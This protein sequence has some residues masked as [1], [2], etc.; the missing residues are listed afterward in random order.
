MSSQ[1]LLTVRDVSLMLG[2][3]EREVMDLAESGKLPAYK[4]G[5][6]YL[7]FKLEQVEEFKKSEM[8]FL[9]KAG[10]SPQDSFRDKFSDFIYFYD[11]YIL[12]SIVIFLILFVIF[13]GY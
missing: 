9:S 2:I 5:G 10:T 4:I 8:P 12:S 13:A 6:E 7:R 1:K 11:F 3:N